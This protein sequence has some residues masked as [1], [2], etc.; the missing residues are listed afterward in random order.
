[1]TANNE[2]LQTGYVTNDFDRAL[3]EVGGTFDIDA[4][5]EMK[6]HRV[7]TGPDQAAI[8]HFALAFKAG[9]QIEIIEP[10]E[11]DVAIYRECLIGEDYQLRLHHIGRHMT[12][13]ERYREALERARKRWPVPVDMAEF[14]GHY[15]YVDAR[16]HYHHYLEF[17]CFPGGSIATDVP[18]D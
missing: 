15:A 3:E 11:G 16:S 1:M 8:G 10:L 6:N 7:P 9:T 5:K 17:L 13:L 2:F 4:F 18:G 12:S 14:G